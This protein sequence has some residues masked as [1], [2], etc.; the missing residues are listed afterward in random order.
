L[1]FE[2]EITV[3]NPEFHKCC[4]NPDSIF[5][6]W[7]DNVN[8]HACQQERQKECSQSS[9][10]AELCTALIRENPCADFLC[11]TTTYWEEKISGIILASYP[12]YKYTRPSVY[13]LLA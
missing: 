10:A 11:C 4:K 12:K 13:V 2:I 9:Y 5:R 7:A 8:F 3:R 6:T 1:E